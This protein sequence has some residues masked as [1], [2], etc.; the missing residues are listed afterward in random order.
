MLKRKKHPLIENEEKHSRLLE[1]RNEESRK[2]YAVVLKGRNHGQ[3]EFKKTIEDTSLRRPF[4][5]KP[6]ISFNHDHDQ[7]RQKFI[8]T[9]PQKIIHSQVCKFLL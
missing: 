7:S 2:S 1:K 8:R 3:L 9:T 4:M 6:Q 5:F